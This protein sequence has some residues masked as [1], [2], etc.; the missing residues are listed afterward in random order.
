MRIA[1]RFRPLTVGG[2]ILALL[3]VSVSA[4]AIASASADD[5]KPTRSDSPA[6]LQP[7][8]VAFTATVEPPQARPGETVTYAITAKIKDSW[9]LY[10]HAEEIPEGVSVLPTRFEQFALGGLEPS[11]KGWT[12]SQPPKASDPNSSVLSFSYHEGSVTWT[13]TLRVPNDA[14]AGA[15]E[16]QTQVFFQLCD[17]SVCKPPTRRTVPT[18][19]LTILSDKAQ[20]GLNRPASS[21]LGLFAPLLVAPQ[22]DPQPERRDSP[23][24]LQP[25]EAQFETT[26]APVEARP[27]EVVNYQ[28]KVSL[29]PTWHIYAISDTIPEGVAAVPT[30]FDLF[31]LSGLEP[32]GDW[33]SDR[34]AH[35]PEEVSGVLAYDYFEDEVVW[36]LPLRVP[37]DASP[38]ERTIQT[39]IQFQLCDPKSCKPPTRVTLPPVSLTV[40]EGDGSTPASAPDPAP[41]EPASV[42]PSTEPTAA[43]APTVQDDAQPE[44]R[45]SPPVLQPKEATFSTAL[46]PVEARPG[47][48]VN[49]QVKVSLA[50]TWHIYAI[51]DTI[52]E[53]VA[54]VPTR[55]D[56]FGL[57]GLEPAG[58]WTSDREAHKPEEVSGVL[59]Y[60][61]FEDEVVWTLPLRVP[62][63]AAPGERAIRTQIQFQLCDPKSCKPPARVTLSPVTLTVLEGDGS[64]PA[65]TLA[66]TSGVSSARTEP[67]APDASAESDADPITPS[68]GVATGE[69]AEKLDQGLLSFMAWSALGGLVAL[70]MPCVWPM[71]PITVNFF[72]KQGQMRKDRSTTGLAVTYCLAIIGVFTL[73]G[74]LF[75]AFFGAASLS[76]LANA[77]WLN[78]LVAG[79]FIAFGLSLLGVFEIRL[80]NF[81]LNASAQGEARGGMVGVMFMALTLTI[82]S[83]TCT[84]PV[85]GALLV[86][87]AGGSY[88]YPVIGLATFAT[89]LA[90]PFF[91]LALAPG[92]LQSMPKSGDWMNAVKVVGGLIEIGAA[93]KFLNTA[94]ISLGA[95]PEDAWLDAQVLLATWVII[96]V[97]CG[98]YLLGMFKTNHDHGDV[99]VGA[100]RILFGTLFLGLGLYFSPALFGYPPK[101][102][103]YDRVVVGLLPA[104][105]DEMDILLQMQKRGMTGGGGGASPG[106]MI[107][108]ANETDP[109]RRAR[110]FHGVWWGMSY[111]AALEQAKA[112]GKPV[113]IDFTGVNCANCRLMEKS[114]IPRPEV[115][116]RL[117]QFIPVQLYT[118][119]VPVD[120]LTPDEKFD[121]A[122]QNLMLEVELTNQQVSPLYVILTPDE[123]LVVTPRGGYIEPAEFVSYLD[124]G[125]AEYSNLAKTAATTE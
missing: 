115:V 77:A 1:R 24:V 125:L 83:F 96:A 87:A 39:Q 74:V 3:M 48:V 117:E 86:L 71:V 89:V 12:P 91:L 36:T 82:T 29:A 112:T 52:P 49:Y 64:T 111:E 34:E 4:P 7:R 122:E 78:L 69:L 90:L 50:P 124:R 35:K 23:P 18:A 73:V 28:V 5:P 14:Q 17:D 101:S 66:S 38:G 59:A 55:F 106:G 41:A 37:A 10:A 45:D 31:G 99:Q 19:T 120:G 42:A 107:V 25:K 121:L 85:V 92:L 118:D 8:E 57:S 110:N 67:V 6:P 114:V 21:L 51:S 54:A 70:L 119:R 22:D 94:E 93:F 61:Y 2:L 43:A 27:G 103:I 26:I 58:D 53:G 40:L 62:A 15:V 80:P 102:K 104:D 32:A 11:K 68:P 65:P 33:T 108:D 44:R 79:L 95:N 123:Q 88:L 84:F 116:Q 72:V 109:V 47:E 63:D 56:L 98:L 60:D 81:L 30:R 113:L 105:A 9:H 20:A 75:S 13:R 100:G 16:L 76:Q 46:E 97:V